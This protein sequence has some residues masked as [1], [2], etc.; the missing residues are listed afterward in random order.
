MIII[1]PRVVAKKH[2]FGSK[3]V[4]AGMGCQTLACA[5]AKSVCHVCLF[6]KNKHS[7]GQSHMR[8]TSL[9]VFF[10]L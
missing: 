7:L 4:V 2:V 10:C 6:K 3:G 9:I 5:L 1:K 8:K